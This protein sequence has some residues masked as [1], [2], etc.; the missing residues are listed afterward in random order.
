MA[1]TIGKEFSAFGNKRAVLLSC[2][3]DSSSGNID[4]GLAVVD[5]LGGLTPVSMATTAVKLKRNIGS[6]ATSRNGIINLDGSA[7]GDVFFLV[8]YGR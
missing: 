3:V 4:T 7:S 8:V 2:S 1:F 5:A 6:G